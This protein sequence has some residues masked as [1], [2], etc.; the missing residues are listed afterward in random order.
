MVLEKG[1][2]KKTRNYK[3]DEI[4]KRRLYSE[5]FPSPFFSQQIRNCK[6][7]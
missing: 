7:D 4:I 1:K 5:V 3:N 6:R 2:E